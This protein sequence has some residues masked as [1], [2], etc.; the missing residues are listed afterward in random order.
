VLAAG[1]TPA[2]VEIG[3]GPQAAPKCDGG[4]LSG[5]HRD[6]DPG[7]RRSPGDHRRVRRP[8]LA[9]RLAD[10]RERPPATQSGP[11]WHYLTVVCVS[12]VLVMVGALVSALRD[13][14]R[15]DASYGY[16][17]LLLVIAELRPLVRA[18]RR[19][20]AGLTSSEA[21][22]FALVLH[23]GLSLALLALVGSITLADALR[24]RKPWR[25]AF[26]ITQYALAYAAAALV[27]TAS[28]VDVGDHHGASI[29]AHDLPAILAAGIAFFVVND[30]LVA[31][32]VARHERLPY[33]TVLLDAP[34][35]RILS[36]TALLCLAPLLVVVA[37]RSSGFLPLLLVPLYAVGQAA[38]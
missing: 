3:L 17:V 12:G 24:G 11:F 9:G 6:G 18:D 10:P 31:C 15:I 19:D 21:F 38:A 4:A 2:A 13:H 28:S 1:V 27:L 23:W 32:A 7:V 30:L 14:P 16:V 5:R 33:R 37:E 20:P 36:T 25:T 34:A 8:G 29:G 22:V 35:Y 26:N